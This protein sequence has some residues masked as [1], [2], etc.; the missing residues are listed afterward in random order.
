MRIIFSVTMGV[1]LIFGGFFYLANVASIETAL[2]VL[3][4]I[5]GGVLLSLAR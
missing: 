4:M 2:G 5:I 1:L 3:I